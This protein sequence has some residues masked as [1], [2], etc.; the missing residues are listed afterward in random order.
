MSKI[1]ISL[2]LVFLC[3]IF[4]LLGVFFGSKMPFK[5]DA[6]WLAKDIDIHSSE[7]VGSLPSGLTLYR[8][9]ELPEI[10][11]YMIF[12]NLK[13][14]DILQESPKHPGISPVAA[15]PKE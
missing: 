4:F 2:I 1:L 13:E 6:F 9:R 5:K 10:T 7:G 11:T 14:R 8:Y 12:I 3:L 15:F